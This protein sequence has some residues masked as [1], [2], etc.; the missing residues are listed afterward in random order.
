MLAESKKSGRIVEFTLEQWRNMELT[1][2]ARHWIVID[3][4]IVDKLEKVDVLKFGEPTT[5]NIEYHTNYRKL[6]EEN[7]IKFD[8]RIRSE[9]RLKEIYESSGLH[10]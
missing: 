7:G 8:K 5:L 2:H 9:K 1:G 10:K 3:A 4:G 6:L